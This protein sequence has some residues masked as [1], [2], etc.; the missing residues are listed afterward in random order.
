MMKLLWN[1]DVLIRKFP[2]LNENIETDVL[3]IGGGICGILCAYRLH[4]LGKKVIVVEAGRIGKK[5]TLR[6]TAVATCLQDVFY[7]DLEYQKAK[8]FFEA[9]SFAIREYKSLAEDFNF[10]LEV[11]SSHKYSDNIEELEL[12]KKCIFDIGGN[13]SIIKKDI[14]NKKY[15]CLMMEEQ[16]QFHPLKLINELSKSLEIYENTK[17][18][19]LKNNIAY[20]NMNMIKAKDIIVT[21]NYPFMKWQGLFFTKLYQMK[22]YVIACENNNYYPFNAIGSKLGDLYYRTY[23]DLLIIGGNDNNLGCEKS[24]FN[25]LI[26]STNDKIIYKWINQD[27][28]SLDKLPYIGKIKKNLYV[29]TGFNMW[30]MTGSMISSVLISDLIR[31]NNNSLELLFSPKRHIKMNV[32]LDFFK[33]TLKELVK[34]RKNKCSHLGCGLVWNDE[35]KSY[36]CPCHGSRFDELGGNLE[37][38]AL[39]D[40]QI[41]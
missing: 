34:V 35:S 20:T 39:E 19:K 23:K 40:S 4:K 17:I 24:G 30:G 9:N 10:D 31:N 18:I 15:N 28:M 2:T 36:E 38:P 5:K 27:S 1:E 41:K 6:T 3:V 8:L 26:T 16:I 32:R 11:V 7:K 13:V 37:G 25:S 12:E 21:T 33:H 14:N 22:S 29:A